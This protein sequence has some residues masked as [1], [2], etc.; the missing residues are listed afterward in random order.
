MKA[1]KIDEIN[2]KITK[3]IKDMSQYEGEVTKEARDIWEAILLSM[4]NLSNVSV[5]LEAAKNYE[6]KEDLD[7]YNKLAEINH[8]QPKKVLPPKMYDIDIDLSKFKTS[9]S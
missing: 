1:T 8:V 3:F 6:L 4:S 7:F 9:N 5:F 2:T